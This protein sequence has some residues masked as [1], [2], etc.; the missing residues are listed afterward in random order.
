MISN[1]IS[2]DKLTKEEIRELQRILEED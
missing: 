2:S 1:L